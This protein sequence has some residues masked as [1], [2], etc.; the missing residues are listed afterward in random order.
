MQKVLRAS[1]LAIAR[2]AKGA[3][4]V[5]VLSNEGNYLHPFYRYGSFFE[6]F[7]HGRRPLGNFLTQSPPATLV[8]VLTSPTAALIAHIPFNHLDACLAAVLPTN[9][10]LGHYYD[11]FV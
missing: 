10:D 3:R 1:I 9:T 2:P 4:G 7:P 11:A 6:P 5:A 8:E